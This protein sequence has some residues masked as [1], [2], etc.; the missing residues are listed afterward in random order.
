MTNKQ[1]RDRTA[2]AMGFKPIKNLDGKQH[3]FQKPN[4]MEWITNDTMDHIAQS[5][6]M[7]MRT[8]FYGSQAMAGVSLEQA[9]INWNKYEKGKL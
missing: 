8:G 1:L 6:M 2:E 9:H 7:S 4:S 5:M 3:A